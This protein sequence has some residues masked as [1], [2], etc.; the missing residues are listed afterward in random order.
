MSLSRLAHVSIRARDLAAS[1]RFYQQALGL[2][3]GSRPPFPFPGAWL[4]LGD[5]EG[6][7]GVVH[8]IDAG[9]DAAAVEAYLGD[10]SGAGG[11]VDHVAF[12][13]DDWP[14]QRARLE[15]LGVAFTE[16]TVPGLGLRQVFVTD[17]SGVVVEL[18]YAAGG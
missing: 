1:R 9:A 17:P 10:R 2:R 6:D 15:R 7:L 8:L 12:A 4:Y 14:A 13:A 11:A 5:D 18:N 3:E 16:R